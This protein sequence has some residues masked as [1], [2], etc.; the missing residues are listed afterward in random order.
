[1]KKIYIGF[2]AVISGFLILLLSLSVVQ[3]DHAYAADYVLGEID[4]SVG[5]VVAGVSNYLNNPFL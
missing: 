5:T 2:K 3:V 1:M 4:S